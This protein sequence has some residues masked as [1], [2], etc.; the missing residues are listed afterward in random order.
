MILTIRIIIVYYYYKNEY[1]NNGFSDIK[2]K[3]ILPVEY[4]NFVTK[5]EAEYI[6]K[7]AL[8]GKG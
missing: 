3:Y 6:R 4:N 5:D 8:G 7:A 1:K 2:A